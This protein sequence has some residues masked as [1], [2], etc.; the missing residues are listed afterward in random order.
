MQPLP[1]RWLI[2]LSIVLVGMC[3]PPMMSA[4]QPAAVLVVEGGTL[5]DGNGGP[6][7]QS[8]AV[9]IQGNRIVGVGRKGFPL[10]IGNTG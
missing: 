10:V 8:A 3:L 4:Q 9:V 2:G 7:V 6:P 5:I 1:N